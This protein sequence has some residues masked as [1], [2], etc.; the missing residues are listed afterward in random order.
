MKFYT[1]CYYDENA[2]EGAPPHIFVSQRAAMRHARDWAR[3]ETAMRSATVY[4]ITFA[5]TPQGMIINA[6]RNIPDTR[7]EIATVRGRLRPVRLCQECECF[8]SPS[9]RCSDSDVWLALRPR[10]IRD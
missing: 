5:G 3:D 9:T 10:A 2:P 6:W 1:V 4:R 7:T 8:H